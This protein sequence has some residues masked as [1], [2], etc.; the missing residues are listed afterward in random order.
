MIV[1]NGDVA[2]DAA[3]VIDACDMVIRFNGCRNFGPAGRR[4]DVIALCNTGRPAKAM[5]G[6]AEW[7]E[8]EAVKAA[9]ALWMVR[10]P[11]KFESLREGILANHPELDDFCDDY[12]DG[13]AAFCA[14]EGK[15]HVVIDGGVHEKADADLRAHDPDLRVVPSSGMIVITHLLTEPAYRQDDIVLTGFS[16]E[17]WDGHPFAAEKRLI[18]AYI[19]EGRLSRLGPPHS[20]TSHG[21]I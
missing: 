13:F 21:D 15:Q 10:D 9:H 18:D 17:G 7:R 6:D 20:S 12:T 8:S 14:A 1:G 5:L 4:T 16:H 11:A 3:P 2:A 19:A